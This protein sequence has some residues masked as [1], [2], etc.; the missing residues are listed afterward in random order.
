[1]T[2]TSPS[3]A[4]AELPEPVDDAGTFEVSL[5]LEEGYRFEVEADAPGAN[6]FHI[7]E[8]PPLGSG[9]Y[10]TPARVLASAMASCLASSFLFCARKGRVDVRRLRVTA[11]GTF[12]RNARKRLRIGALHVELFPVVAP[13]D[14]ARMERCLELFEDFCV[15][16]Q[17]VRAGIPVVVGVE[18]HRE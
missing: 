12:V 10:P 2:M 13:G 3:S 18:M 6:G 15:V 7:D 4:D 14:E 9:H 11:T 8:S 5:T 16:T 1:M 17:S